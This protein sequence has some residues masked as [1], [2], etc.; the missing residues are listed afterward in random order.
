MYIEA[1]HPALAAVVSQDA[2]ARAQA[3][4]RPA[5]CALTRLGPLQMDTP[6]A[7]VAHATSESRGGELTAV[8]GNFRAIARLEAEA[9]P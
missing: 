3:R 6:V 1:A 2:R 9:G 4:R 5:Q 8:K 7:S